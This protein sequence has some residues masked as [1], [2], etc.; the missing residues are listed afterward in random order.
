MSPS[1]GGDMTEPVAGPSPRVVLDA[2]AFVGLLLD[3]GERGARVGELVAA[4]DVHAP[5]LLPFEVANVLRRLHAAGRL[6]TTEAALA[7]ADAARLP[8]EL[9]PFEAVAARTVELGGA[10]T[11]YDASYVALAELL[12]ARLVTAD[13]RLAAAPGLRCEVVVV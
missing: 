8:V 2:S 4:G 13:R 7:R 12:D 5:A 6:S 11:A 1:I 9:W 10:L 3:P